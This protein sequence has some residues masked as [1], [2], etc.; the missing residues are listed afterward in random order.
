MLAGEGV[1]V[2]VHGRDEARTTSVAEAIRA[3]GGQADLALGDL[4]TD[5]GADTVVAMARGGGEIDILVNNAGSYQGRPWTELTAAQWMDSYQRNVVSGVRLINRLVPGMRE[6]G[7]GRVIQIGGGL[8]VAL[9]ADQPDYNAALAARHNLA[10][11]LAREL[12]YS[13]VTSNVVAPG[14]ILV[15]SVK[16]LL[17]RAAPSYGWG[18]T[19]PE[20]E[21]GAVRDMVPNDVGRLG[22]P[23]D[24]A[25]AVAYLASPLADYVS[26]MVPRVDGGTIRSVN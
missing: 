17:T 6:R 10:V 12:K 5:D 13:G 7:W 8:A 19:W 15:P 25:A 11:S 18:S 24:I 26:G 14:A 9:V 1:Q 4:S 21:R 3:A 23:E 20:V 22:R 16:D 2:V